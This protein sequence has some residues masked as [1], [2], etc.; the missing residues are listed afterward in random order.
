MKRILGDV[1]VKDLDGCLKKILE[2]LENKQLGHYYLHQIGQFLSE[3]PADVLPQKWLKELSYRFVWERAEEHFKKT[4][5]LW[6]NELAWPFQICVL[7]IGGLNNKAL[8]K[9][10]LQKFSDSYPENQ[11]TEYINDFDLSAVTKKRKIRLIRL[12]AKHLGF[13]NGTGFEK[14]NCNHPQFSLSPCPPETAFF[15]RPLVKEYFDS[16]ATLFAVDHQSPNMVDKTKKMVF[17]F[18]R[19]NKNY[20]NDLYM[21]V[22]AITPKSSGGSNYHWIFQY[23]APGN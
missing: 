6:Y 2:L 19:P 5:Q 21:G 16:N 22:W 9:K 4:N 7:E 13:S 20:D 1:S 3:P 10:W 18:D 11:L 14:I 8:R 17:Y 15:M 12:Q 23:N